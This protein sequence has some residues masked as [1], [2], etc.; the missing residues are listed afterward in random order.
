MMKNNVLKA[1]SKGIALSLTIS[2]FAYAEETKA[3]ANESQS[4]QQIE[5]KAKGQTVYFNAWGGS[6]EINDYLKWADKQLQKSYSVTMKQVKVTDIA[7]TTQRLLAE[8]TAGKNIN[9][10]VDLVWINGENFRSMKQHHLL[11]GPFTQQLPN[12]KYVDTKLPIDQDFSEPTEGYEAPWGVGQLVFIYDTSV[13]KQ[14]PR[15]FKELLALAQKYPGKISYPRPPEFHGSSFLKAALLELTDDK[16]ALYQPLSLPAEKTLFDNVTAPLW[17]YLDQLHKVAWRGG[18]QFPAGTAETVQLLDDQQLL[19][20]ITFNPNAASAAIENGN[21]TENAKTYA[22]KQGALT[23]IHFLAIPWNASA[24]EGALVAIN[25]L[26]SPEAQARKSDTKIWGDPTVLKAEAFSQL[27]EPYKSQS[28]E[29][30]PSIAE[31]N[32][33]WLMAIEHEWQKRYGH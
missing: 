14:P 19:L 23:N 3:P 26:M 6:Q 29:L 21:L 28:F 9:G 13:L 10:G 2:S 17:Q 27:A 32:P 4:W 15:S 31:P 18:K 12:W 11:Y 24:K 25:F 8:K 5:Q 20:A 30:Y 7:E 1:L 16:K 33:T 22:F